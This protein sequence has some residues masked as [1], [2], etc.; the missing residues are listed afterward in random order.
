MKLTDELLKTI[1]EALAK[2]LPDDVS[3]ML[4][5]TEIDDNGDERAVFS[6]TKCPLCVHAMLGES[7]EQNNMTHWN[8]TS[9][10]SDDNLKVH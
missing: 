3:V 1:N 7:I 9:S 4:I 6:T 5:L 8:D 10:H 2:L